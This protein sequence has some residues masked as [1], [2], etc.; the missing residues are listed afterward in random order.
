MGKRWA[1]IYGAAGV[2]SRI[3]S[4]DDIV[5]LATGILR[6]SPGRSFVG[7]LC[8]TQQ[9][10]IFGGRYLLSRTYHEIPYD[11]VSSVSVDGFGLAGVGKGMFRITAASGTLDIEVFALDAANEVASAVRQYLPRLAPGPHADTSSSERANSGE[12][13]ASLGQL[14]DLRSRGALSDEEYEEKKAEL[15]RRI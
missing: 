7:L 10:F 13:L 3:P 14:A 5:A 12:A 6:A 2:A 15:L 11:R 4:D 9:R 8:A 1:W